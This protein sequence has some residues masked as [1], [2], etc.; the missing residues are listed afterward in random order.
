VITPQCTL[1]EHAG[2]FVPDTVGLFIGYAYQRQRLLRQYRRIIVQLQ[3]I[4]RT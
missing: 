1:S 3:L 4:A 2:R